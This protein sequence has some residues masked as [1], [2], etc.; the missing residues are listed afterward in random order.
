M[1]RSYKKVS[2]LNNSIQGGITC[3]NL[4][5]RNRLIS[6]QTL[7][8]SA[9]G[10]TGATGNYGPIYPGIY[11]G[12][13]GNNLTGPTGSIGISVI[14]YGLQGST[15]YTGPT[16]Y[17]TYTGIK[18]PTGENGYS[19]QGNTGYIGMTGEYNEITG[20]TGPSISYSKISNTFNGVSSSSNQPIRTISLNTPCYVQWSIKLTSTN[21]SD[22]VTIYFGFGDNMVPFIGNIFNVY[23]DSIL[24]SQSP[25]ATGNGIYSSDITFQCYYDGDSSDT[26][27]ISYEIVYMK[28]FNT[29]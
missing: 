5:I 8:N 26:F 20:P 19:Y 10:P 29:L 17:Q 23:Y 14:S 25:H 16:G 9:T 24:V 2:Q 6:T 11:T 1:I 18:G 13:T 7:Y 3:E 12:P 21:I 28:L 22:I 27:K 15:G 4:N